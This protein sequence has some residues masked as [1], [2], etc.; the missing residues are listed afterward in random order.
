MT[1]GSKI[2][3][4]LYGIAGAVCLLH[5]VAVILAIIF[6][7]QFIKNAEHDA[8]VMHSKLTIGESHFGLSTDNQEA[9]REPWEPV[10]PWPSFQAACRSTT[11]PSEQYSRNKC[12]LFLNLTHSLVV[13]RGRSQSLFVA[14]GMD[15]ALNL[16]LFILLT[17]LQF[18]VSGIGS[19]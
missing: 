18:V 2:H 1:S 15:I 5:L 6:E 4:V 13:R 8:A 16:V 14:S 17:V 9:R 19:V 12:V 10:S 3:R 11:L 7:E